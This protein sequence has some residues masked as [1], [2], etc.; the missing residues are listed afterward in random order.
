MTSA[1]IAPV[2]SSE[3]KQPDPEDYQVSTELY[4]GPLDLLLSLIQRAELDITR[5]AL[6]QVTDQYLAHLEHLPT[7]DP[8]EVSAFLVIAARL[9]QIKS[10]VLL[11]RPPASE[12][13]DDELDAGEALAQQLILYKRFKELSAF[14]GKRQEKNLHTYLRLAAPQPHIEPQ[15]EMGDITIDD[16]LQAA[17]SVFSI[18]RR[19]ADIGTVV[20][21]PKVTIR[22]KIN[23]IM[24]KLKNGQIANF[25]T[26]LTS[27]NRI[28]VVV[29]FLAM[30]EL[31]KRHIIEADQ[32]ELFGDINLH[33]LR[34]WDGSEITE[35]EFSD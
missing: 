27:S 3:K 34:E 22:E 28:E 9:V 4:E 19:L 31:I 14:I 21:I 33:S 20:N 24:E 10:S 7:K 29:S 8:A 17:R 16:L 26:L 18:T 15:F 12:P 25:R 2:N 32:D 30:L 11:P 35:F 6:A 5:L 23:V 1:I 13:L